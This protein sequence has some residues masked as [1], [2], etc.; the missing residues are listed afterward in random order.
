[1]TDNAKKAAKE[2]KEIREKLANNSYL[3]TYYEPQGILKWTPLKE[4]ETTVIDEDDQDFIE[5]NKDLLEQ[6]KQI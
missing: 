5:E 4:R 6:Q 2:A 3:R 1:L